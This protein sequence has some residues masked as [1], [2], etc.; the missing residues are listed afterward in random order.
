MMETFGWS[1]YPKCDAV[2][3]NKPVKET[4]PK[5][6]APLLLEKTTKK[7]G[8]IRYCQ[9]KECDYKMAVDN[10]NVTLG[11]KTEDTFTA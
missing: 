7:D 11:D 5:C 9:N 2:Y 4:C 1:N 8:T 6:S 3:W 10:T